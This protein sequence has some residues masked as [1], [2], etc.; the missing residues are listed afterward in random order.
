MLLKNLFGSLIAVDDV[1]VLVLSDHEGI[2]IVRCRTTVT[3]LEAHDAILKGLRA[4]SQ[5]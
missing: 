5:S 2:L 4:F 1:L 3:Q